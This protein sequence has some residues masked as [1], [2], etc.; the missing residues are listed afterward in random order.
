MIGC[1]VRLHS[2]LF[3][4]CL[5]TQKFEEAASV[6]QVVLDGFRYLHFTRDV[7]LKFVFPQVTIISLQE[8]L[9]SRSPH[10]LLA[11]SEANQ[12]K[13]VSWKLC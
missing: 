10:S 2:Q 1:R 5:A 3:S 13:L 4:A 6:G 8:I 9:L 7:P 11:F 12:N